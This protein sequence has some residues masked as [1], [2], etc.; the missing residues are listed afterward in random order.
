MMKWTFSGEGMTTRCRSC[1]RRIQN[2]TNDDCKEPKHA[3]YYERFKKYMRLKMK[4]RYDATH[5]R[6]YQTRDPQF[7][8]VKPDKPEKTIRTVIKQE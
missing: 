4:T 7:L 5:N 6:V 3:A 2:R 1:G 8:T